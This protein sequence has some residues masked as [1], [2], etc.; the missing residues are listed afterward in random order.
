MAEGMSWEGKK[1]QKHSV[2]VWDQCVV[3]TTVICKPECGGLIKLFYKLQ[4]LLDLFRLLRSSMHLVVPETQSVLLRHD[5][6]N[7]V[8]S[9]LCNTDSK[10]KNKICSLNALH[11]MP[12]MSA[13]PLA[14]IMYFITSTTII[15]V[16]AV[17]L[18]L[19]SVA[20]YT[21]LLLWLPQHQPIQIKWPHQVHLP[22]ATVY[23]SGYQLTPMTMN[24]HQWLPSP[25]TFLL[26]TMHIPRPQCGYRSEVSRSSFWS[27][28]VMIQRYNTD[29]KIN[30]TIWLFHFSVH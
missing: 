24:W 28:N 6:K 18:L 23:P 8:K 13:L 7:Q 10:L 20:G 9:D 2:L 16:V 26:L 17:L 3:F 21:F 14:L 29:T 5:K 11:W 1:H 25:T 27:K 22:S 15:T 12:H 4:V 19:P 30:P